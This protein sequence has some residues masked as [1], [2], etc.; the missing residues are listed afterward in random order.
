MATVPALTDRPPAQRFAE[1]RDE[2]APWGDPRP[3]LLEA[4][5][6]ILEATMGNELTAC[7]A[8]RRPP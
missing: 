7:R 2:D 6:T 4:A 5:K 1:V 3:E 8:P